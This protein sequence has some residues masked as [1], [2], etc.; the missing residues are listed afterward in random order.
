MVVEVDQPGLGKV[1]QLGT[2]VK[3]TRTP[4][5]RPARRRPS[6]STPRPCCAEAGYS[7]EEIAA[8][9]ESGAAAG[10]AARP[11]RRSSARERRQA[12]RGC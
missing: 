5:T 3:L 9:L 6:A 12:G 2:P 1:R 7:A 11:S 8:L 10:P 4:A